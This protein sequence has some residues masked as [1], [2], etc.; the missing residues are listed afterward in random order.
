[1]RSNLSVKRF[2]ADLRLF[3]G[4][5]TWTQFDDKRTGVLPF[6]FDDDFG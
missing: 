5:V 1:M 6:V 2:F 4:S 3:C